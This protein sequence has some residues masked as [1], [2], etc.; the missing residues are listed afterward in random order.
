VDNKTHRYGSALRILIGMGMRYCVAISIRSKLWSLF[1]PIDVL[2]M[3]IHV[4]LLVSGRSDSHDLAFISTVETG[5][6]RSHLFANYPLSRDGVLSNIWHAYIPYNQT[7]GNYGTR[8]H[9]C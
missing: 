9:S 1:V 6:V 3:E 4:S 7:P 8:S 5:C 2:V